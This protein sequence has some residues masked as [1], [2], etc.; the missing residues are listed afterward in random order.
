MRF[1]REVAPRVG[2]PARPLLTSRRIDPDAGLVH[3]RCS[4][5]PRPREQGDQIAGCDAR[6]ARGSRCASSRGSTRRCSARRAAR[7]TDVAEPRLADRPGAGGQLLTGVPRALRRADRARAPRGLRAARREPR[8]RG[9]ADRQ[10]PL[11]LVHGDYRLD[12][13]LFGPPGA[14]PPLDR[15]R[16]ADGRAGARADATPR[17]SSAAALTVDDRRAHEEALLARLPRRLL[18]AR[19]A[20]LRLGRVLGGRTGAR[21]L[22]RPDGGRRRRCSSSA[23]SAATTCS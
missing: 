21:L 10:P 19:R 14:R 17:T 16:L 11:G 9:C 12:N 2:G 1:Y 3:A 13:M 23:P 22:R 6:A 18:G 7:A 8:R 15:R 20:R 4:T 5:T